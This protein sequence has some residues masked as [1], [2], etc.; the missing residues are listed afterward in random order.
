MPQLLPDQTFYP[1]PTMAMSAR[2]KRSP[3]SRSST[4]TAEGKDAMAVIDVDP[5]SNAHAGA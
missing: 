1:S 5:G 4:P 2:R 3:I